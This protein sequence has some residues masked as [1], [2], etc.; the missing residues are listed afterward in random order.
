MEPLNP[1][2]SNILENVQDPLSQHLCKIL[3]AIS[4]SCEEMAERLR[5]FAPMTG[6]LWDGGLMFVG[7]AL[8]GWNTEEFTAEDAK[9]EDKR[10]ELVKNAWTISRTGIG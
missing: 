1:N 2:P 9:S 4:E 5:L 10:S 6:G 8:Y 7:R 3:A